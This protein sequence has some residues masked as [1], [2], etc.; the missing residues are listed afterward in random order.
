[1]LFCTLFFRTLLLWLACSA[2]LS[3]DAANHSNQPLVSTLQELAADAQLHQSDYWYS[4]MHY[5]PNRSTGGDGVESH[6]DDKRFFLAEDG[7]YNPDTELK[8]TINAVFG[9]PVE[10]NKTD[11]DCR[12]VERAKW[13]RKELSQ[14]PK[15]VPQSCTDY[16]SWRDNI[17]L[18]SVTLVFPASF[19]NS[20]SSM[21]GHTLLRFDPENLQSSSPLLSWSLNFAADVGDESMSAG[22]A[23]KGIAG[24][25]PGN[26]NSIP[27]FQKLQ[28][29]GAIENRDIWE[30]RLDLTT[31]EIDRMLDHA[32]ELHDISF[33]Y[34]FFRENCSFRL[35]ELIDLARPGLALA[36]Q[37]PLTAIP[38]DTVKA[39]K[40]AGIVDN[41][42]YRP[43]LG[44]RLNH[45]IASIDP[46]QR[47]WID[48]IEKSPDITENAQF[49]K[50]EDSEQARIIRAAN[51]LLTFR[52][53]RTAMDD[54]TATRRLQLLNRVSQLPVE[55]INDVPRPVSPETAHETTTLSLTQG[56]Q[57][58]QNYTELGLRL[59]YHD[60]LD[61]NAG[62]AKGSGITL[63][64]I[65]LRLDETDKLRLDA[66]DVV[67]LQSFNNRFSHINTISWELTAGLNRNTLLE[68][69]GL[70]ARLD[71]YVGKSLR[72]G[73]ANIGYALLGASANQYVNPGANYLNA[74]VRLG[75]LSYNRLGASR[76]EVAVNS[77]QTLSVQTIL[78]LQHNIPVSKNHAVRIKASAQRFNGV[79]DNRFSLS[80]RFYF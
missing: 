26:F 52:S 38:A 57:M 32:W 28:E 60:V 24:G 42:E 35:L 46:G 37:F 58:Q 75:L 71:G 49:N 22:Y 27:Y 80:Y 59:S 50:L 76:L 10:S 78:N 67:K 15:D 63:G 51:Q 8:A 12:F 66:F 79:T 18:G 20:P 62:Y 34:F 74:H 44:S 29:Y 40:N 1:M 54:E 68:D 45:A 14:P 4:L 53:R 56:R 47:A 36:D 72:L 21:F 65:R 5:Y 13:L 61:R 17:G 70:G 2:A 48:K 69:N 3:V 23:F 39:V 9:L 77:F 31:E 11:I 30:Y 25:Y 41:I 6:V 7:K 64:D 55:I 73:D 16:H 19:L 43:S 33:D